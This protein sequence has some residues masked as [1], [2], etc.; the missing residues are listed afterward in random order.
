MFVSGP[1]I[2]SALF[3]IQA[4][5]QFEAG[6]RI[7]SRVGQAPSLTSSN[8]VV[9]PEQTQ[10]MVVATPL[11]SLRW[12]DGI[13]DLHVDSATRILWRPVPLFDSR[14][15]FL[16]TLGATH[17]RRPSRRSQLQLNVRASY[18]E[19]DY[20]SLQ[21]Q[22]P[23]QPSLP[24]ALTMLMVDATAGASWRSSRR[25]TLTLQLGAMHSR[26]FDTQGASSGTTGT[27]A[28]PTQTTVTVAPGMTY[29]LARRSTL[30]ALVS[31]IDTDSQGI[32]LASSQTGVSSQTGEL[33]A[34]SI[35]PQVGVRQALTRQ[36]QL[37]LAVG[38][39]YT[40]ALRR[41][42][43]PNLAWYPVPLLQLDLNSVLLRTRT[44]IVRSTLGAG[45]TAFVDPVLGVAV[46]R[47]LAQAS[48][49]AQLGPWSVGA[50]CAFSTDLF[51]RLPTIGGSTPGEI[52][53]DETFVTAEI[54][55]RYR[56][57]RHLIVELGGRYTERAPYLGAPGFAWHYRELWLYL[58]MTTFSRPSS[59]RS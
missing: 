39:A 49:D 15:L 43:A 1:A 48:V 17:L 6:A 36:H 18:G 34:L 51:G 56:S 41:T 55:V 31:I 11:L 8:Q 37:H 35:Q 4:A 45:T 21:Q 16:E 40:V 22:L 38:F 12:I 32:S 19:Q 30:N 54:P 52:L 13:D 26:S 25:T 53:P 33:N 59:T 23:N 7:E 27:F 10:V 44:A 46:T 3:L 58:S 57:S 9:P 28:L 24:L 47:G 14:P 42:D 5:A 50:R 20:T 29:A 2:L